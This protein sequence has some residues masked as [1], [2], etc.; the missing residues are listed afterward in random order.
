MVG[1]FALESRMT[2]RG[3]PRFCR[4]SPRVFGRSAEKIVAFR[5][6]AF[7][8]NLAQLAIRIFFHL[9]LFWGGGEGK[10]WLYPC[11]RLAEDF[12]VHSCQDGVTAAISF[13]KLAGQLL[14]SVC[15]LRVTFE[16]I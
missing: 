13:C 3:F 1:Y 7:R 16:E 4:F 5:S 11:L 15:L 2:G 12:R 14:S 6:H 8:A 10:K 9:A